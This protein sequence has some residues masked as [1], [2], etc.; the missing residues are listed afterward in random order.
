[1][2]IADAGQAHRRRGVLPIM[3]MVRKGEAFASAGLDEK[4]S[5]GSAVRGWRPNAG[6]LSVGG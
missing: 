4:I 3:G 5:G 2:V 6:R 1:V